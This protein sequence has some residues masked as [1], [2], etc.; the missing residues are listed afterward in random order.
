MKI[1]D[2]KHDP[3]DKNR[4]CGP[5]AI[6]ALTGMNSGEA[7]RLLRAV[8]GKRSIM[9]TSTVAVLRALREC[10][11]QPKMRPCR[12]EH[13]KNI[14]G[15]LKVR[16]LDS[17]AG[18][19]KRTVKER[20]P[21]RVFLIVAGNHWQVITG[22]RYVCGISGEIVSITD[23]KVKRRAKVTEVYEM[24]APNGITVPTVA[25]KGKSYREKWATESYSRFRKFAREHGLQYSIYPESGNHYINVLPTTFWP[26]GLETLHYN[27]DETINRLQACY[28]N[29]A[30]VEDGYYS[31]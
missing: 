24:V 5:S 7:A 23:K 13:Y 10:G 21:G 6:S 31:E 4:F 1:F 14:K 2:V 3:A 29:P 28:E 16:G 19:L 25:K 8:T 15:K 12:V 20:T 17:V 18:W 22:R 30:L 27:F 26:D 9:G 11:I